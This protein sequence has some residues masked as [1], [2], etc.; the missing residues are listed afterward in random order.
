M[1]RPNA[2]HTTDTQKLY[3]LTVSPHCSEHVLDCGSACWPSPTKRPRSGSAILR[4]FFVSENKE[5]NESIR[6][7]KERDDY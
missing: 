3:P 5:R 7:E 1:V 2:A 6:G 4:L